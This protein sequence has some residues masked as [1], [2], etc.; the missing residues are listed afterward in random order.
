MFT[1]PYFWLGYFNKN[2]QCL[3]HCRKT[4]FKT[5]SLILTPLDVRYHFTAGYTW[6]PSQQ[7]HWSASPNY[8]WSDSLL[9]KNGCCS[10]NKQFFI[11]SFI[12]LQTLSPIRTRL[13]HQTCYYDWGSTCGCSRMLTPWHSKGVLKSTLIITKVVGSIHGYLK[14]NKSL[15]PN[16]H[17][18]WL[19]IW[20]SNP[21]MSRTP[22][23]TSGNLRPRVATKWFPARTI[24][25]LKWL[26]SLDTQEQ[27]PQ[28]LS[29]SG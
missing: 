27:I 23:D 10:I 13:Q 25:C 29:Q 14:I 19:E 20:G 11:D 1:Q 12:D 22:M 8:L 18:I 26:T 7:Q 4:H 24:K 6:S 3:S 5:W 15:W 17:G 9:F 28:I 2:V 16:G 21:G